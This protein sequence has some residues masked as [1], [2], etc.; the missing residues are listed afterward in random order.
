MD[1]IRILLEY[2]TYPLWLLDDEGLTIDTALP[3]EWADDEELDQ[4]LTKVMDYYS[5]LFVDTKTEFTYVGFKDDASKQAF[6]K[7]VQEA[8]NQVVIK[9]NGKYKI[10]NDIKF[11][12]L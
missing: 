12:N 3:D 9:N 6:I 5:G 1:T 10:I 8:V 4:L 2:G 11:E 7:L